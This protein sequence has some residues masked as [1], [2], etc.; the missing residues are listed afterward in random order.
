[1]M[2]KPSGWDMGEWYE[3]PEAR[4]V[5]DLRSLGYSGNLHAGML[6][7]LRRR[8]GDRVTGRELV[9]RVGRGEGE[10]VRVGGRVWL[11]EWVGRK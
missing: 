3:A 5:A 1:M 6:W 10:C 9:G 11:R 2:V 8:R 4:A 7:A